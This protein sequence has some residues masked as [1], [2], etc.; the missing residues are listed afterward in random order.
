MDDIDLHYDHVA[1]L[2]GHYLGPCDC[3]LRRAGLLPI[4]AAVTSAVADRPDPTCPK[5]QG[6]GE[7]YAHKETP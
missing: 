3:H 6:D 7:L 1:T 4:D 2:R 5:C